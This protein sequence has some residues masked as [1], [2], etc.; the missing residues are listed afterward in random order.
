MIDNKDDFE[1]VAQMMQQWPDGSIDFDK[2]ITS[3]KRKI[4]NEISNNEEFYGHLKNFSKFPS[5]YH[6]GVFYGEN[7]REE[8]FT[9]RYID[10]HWMLYMI[11]NT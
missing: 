8:N 10:E 6:G 11:P 1:Y 3:T 2:G 9:R 7:T 4:A 5:Q